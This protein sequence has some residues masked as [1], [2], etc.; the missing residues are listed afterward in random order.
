MAPGPGDAVAPEGRRATEML[1]RIER[2]L[3]RAGITP[4]DGA[5]IGSRL[6]A[7]LRHRVRVLGDDEHFDALHPA[8]TLLILLDD[9][10][11]TD[12]DV[13]EAAAS[14]ES[15]HAALRIPAANGLAARVPAPAEAGD[16]LL[17]RLVVE[18]E[19]VR[20]IALAERLDHARHLHL[21]EPAAWADFH[22]SIGDVYA[23]VALRTHP[24]L[25]RRYAWWWRTFRDRFLAPEDDR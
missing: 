9:C 11:V 10:D 3:D 7:A 17:E 14:V 20:L 23:P 22:A 21:R 4:S 5:R 15:E 2:Q 18:D 25:A 24:R 6:E 8:R 13:L 1:R 16:S 12:P 19:S